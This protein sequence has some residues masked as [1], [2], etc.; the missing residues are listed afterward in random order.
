MMTSFPNEMTRMMARFRHTP[1]Q[2]GLTRE[3]SKGGR[4]RRA[5]LM[6]P[7]GRLR[8]R[9]RTRELAMLRGGGICARRNSSGA[10]AVDRLYTP[11][12]GTRNQTQFPCLN[13]H[14][15][16]SSVG[17]RRQGRQSATDRQELVRHAQQAHCFLKIGNL[18][19]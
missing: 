17:S 18:A 4:D 2:R 11:E 9:G 5:G 1:P 6:W 8:K 19:P 12:L 3:K 15:H 13:N 7:H 10:S 14:M 16:T